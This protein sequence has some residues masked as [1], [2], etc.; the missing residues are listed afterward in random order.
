[1]NSDPSPYLKVTRFASIQRG[2]QQ[3]FLML[4]VDAFDRPDPGREREDLGSENGGVVCQPPF[5]S[6]TT[7]G[8][9]HSSMVVQMEN[10]GANS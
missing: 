9:R 1:M 5:F 10:V 2:M 8:L 4:H 7:G 3:H 6:Q